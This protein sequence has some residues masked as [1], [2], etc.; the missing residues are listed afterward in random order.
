MRKSSA[1]PPPF[2]DTDNSQR[3][4]VLPQSFKV[5]IMNRTLFASAMALMVCATAVQAQ[6][7]LSTTRLEA[8]QHMLNS[9][10]GKALPKYEVNLIATLEGENPTM[11]AQ[12]VQTM[13]E[14]EQMFPK[15]VFKSL[16]APLGAKLKDEN[17]DPTVRLLAA[18][19]LDELHS[20]A[21]DAVIKDVAGSSQ[22]KGL[23]N[24]CKALLV[25]S[26][27]K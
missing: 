21:G 6:E 13:R 5:I 25:R 24:L 16:I 19:A 23:Q 2:I 10:M 4:T 3:L 8:Q 22:D 14:L 9:S 26:Q 12:A 17:A 18:L 15:Y 7:N 1:C 20:D 27:Y 11:Q